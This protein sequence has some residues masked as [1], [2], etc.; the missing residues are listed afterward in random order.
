MER[1]QIESHRPL[2]LQELKVSSHSAKDTPPLEGFFG[3]QTANRC[4]RSLGLNARHRADSLEI[5]AAQLHTGYSY[6]P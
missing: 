3:V 1:L 5:R 2:E 6:F 4:I